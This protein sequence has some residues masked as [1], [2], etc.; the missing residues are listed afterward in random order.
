VGQSRRIALARAL[1]RKTPLLL[2]DEP[3]EGLD[4]D[5]AHELLRDLAAA[6]GSRSV[7]MISHDELPAGAV[8]AR[9]RLSE[10]RLLPDPGN[11][12]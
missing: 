1:L 11:Y 3:T 10:G 9:Y 6:S 5:T 12:P 4:V 8:H 2:L 7:L